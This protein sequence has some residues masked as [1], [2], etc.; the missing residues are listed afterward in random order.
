MTPVTRISKRQPCTT[1]SEFITSSSGN[2][3]HTCLPHLHPP[4]V[5]DQLECM[6]L[7]LL[8]M[9]VIF[10]SLSYLLYIHLTLSSQYMQQGIERFVVLLTDFLLVLNDLEP[11]S[12]LRKA[13]GKQQFEEHMFSDNKYVANKVC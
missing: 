9:K 1:S 4:G 3:L 13:V 12:H 10:A 8:P 11:R 7:D 2:G 6:A 5:L